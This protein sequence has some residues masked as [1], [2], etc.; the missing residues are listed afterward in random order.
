MTLKTRTR[1]SASRKA[2]N[3]WNEDVCLELLEQ[4]W[5]LRQSMLDSEKRHAIAISAV[6]AHQRE[7]ARNLIHYLALR[8]TDLRKLQEKLSWLGVSSLGRAESHVL[9]N[10]DKVIGILHRLTGQPW[11]DHSE[12]EPAGSVSGRQL[13]Q[14][15][16]KALLG[17][18]LRE[19]RVRI[20]VTLPSEAAKD[21]GL[22]RRLVQAGMDVARI[23]CAHDDAQAWQAMAQRV[24]RAAK[25]AQRDI[26][27]LMDLGGPKIRTGA[28]AP[29]PAVIKLKPER[30]ALGNAVASSRLRI[31]AAGSSTSTTSTTV[32]ARIV[33][34]AGW[35]AP[36]RVG[37]QIEVTDARTKK[38]R[39]LVVECDADGVVAECLETYYLTPDTALS[40]KSERGHKV[41][42]IYP[43][44]IEPLP[45]VL[46]LHR[47]DRLHLTRDGNGQENQIACTLPQVFTQVHAGERVWFDDGRIGG[48]VRRASAKGLEVEIVQAR[49]GGESLL[50]DKGINFP[51]SHLEL[52]ALT[53]KDLQDLQTVAQIADLV[54]LSFSQE[55]ADVH[56]LLQTLQD[57]GGKRV[58]VVLKIET[59][60]GFENLPE[61]ML[62]AMAAPSAG[63][64]IARG[65]LAVECGYERLA[66][67]QEEIL[68][69]SEAAHMPVI[70]ATQ[71]LETLAKSGVPSRAEISDA[72]MGVR[73]EC[74]MLNKGPYITEA[75][76]ML[77]DILR[78]M[79][80]HQTKKTSLLRALRAWDSEEPH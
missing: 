53:D 40:Y 16:T 5:A 65:D 51:D 32:R 10:L 29:G 15:H 68:W 37:K 49:E 26:Q 9:A 55:A 73:A 79:A 4:L 61:L 48:V 36:L 52:P 80:G 20:M 39:L 24:R 57:Q 6:G 47:G 35:L 69:C 27:I 31:E 58:G 78:R 72:G 59:M 14:S 18:A 45:G 38:R 28:V 56:Q 21:Y 2:S 7:S 12:D 60:R 66:E 75:I 54:G 30:D 8:A 62:A 43:D 76:R 67:V 22:V 23:N 46:R 17:P 11:Q 70:W 1:K 50:A 71:V 33:A 3:P 41:L 77:D 13:L 19:R 42:S 74:V 63:V 25:A 34:D 64:M 44:G